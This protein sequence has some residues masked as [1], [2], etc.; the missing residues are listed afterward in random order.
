MDD[1]Q[2]TPCGY[3]N[4][5]LTLKIFRPCIPDGRI[6]AQIDGENNPGGLSNLIPPA[7]APPV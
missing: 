2:M 3:P 1:G 5:I 6:D 4:L 7:H